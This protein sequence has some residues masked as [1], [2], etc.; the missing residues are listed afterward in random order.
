LYFVEKFSKNSEILNFAKIR[1]V[2]AE[3]TDSRKK[4]GDTQPD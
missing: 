2:A 4:D 1:L 3:H